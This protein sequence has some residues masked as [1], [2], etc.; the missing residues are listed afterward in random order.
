[1]LNQRWK[2]IINKEALFFSLGLFIVIGIAECITPYV[3]IRKATEFFLLFH[4]YLALYFLIL[5]ARTLVWAVGILMKGIPS[6]NH[7]KIG[8]GRKRQ[9]PVHYVSIPSG[10]TYRNL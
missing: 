4:S 8:M 5:L 6:L 3:I 9:F 7:A 10:N 2:R 1:M